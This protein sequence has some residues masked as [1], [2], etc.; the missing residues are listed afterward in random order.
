[1]TQQSADRPWF[2]DRVRTV[3]DAFADERDK[4]LPLPDEPF[5]VHERLDVEV[6]KTPYARFSQ[7]LLD[8]AR[9]HW[10]HPDCARRALGQARECSP[11]SR[12]MVRRQVLEAFLARGAIVEARSGP[13]A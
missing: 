13:A 4:L 8:P 6:G 9:A 10:A 12:R 5:P 1:M 11:G 2:E 7:R 3:R